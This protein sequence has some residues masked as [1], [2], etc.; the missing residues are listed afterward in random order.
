[1]KQP[2]LASVI[3]KYMFGFS[4]ALILSVV[5]YL[6]VVQKWFD[7]PAISMAALLLLA[8][9]QLAVQ[10]VCFLHLGMKGEARSRTGVVIFTIVM[11]LIIVVGS[12][13]VM[14]NLDYRMGMSPEAMTEYMLEQNKKG[15]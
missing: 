11:M 8:A 2:S 7:S 12:L 10:L 15:F 14:R 13:W 5:A 3:T 6:L 9:V 1:M 4:S